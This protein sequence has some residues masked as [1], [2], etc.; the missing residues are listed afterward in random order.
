[1]SDYPA[2]DPDDGECGIV[3]P[4]ATTLIAVSDATGLAV[5][6]RSVIAFTSGLAVEVDLLARE[7]AASNKW[8]DAMTTSDSEGLRVGFAFSGEPTLMPAPMQNLG[9]PPSWLL[10]RAGG[11][12]RRFSI[13]WWVTPYPAHRRLVLGMAWT[14][15]AIERTAVTID[16]LSPAD[17]Q[18]RVVRVW[19]R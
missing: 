19:D 13:A 16:V 6:L 14:R 4:T 11:G 10:N 1:M 9:S 2:F 3:V 15:A 8:Q 5:A 18:E 12:D 17:L 7:P